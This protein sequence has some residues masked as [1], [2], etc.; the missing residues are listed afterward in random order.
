VDSAY[1]EGSRAINRL[2]TDFVVK[3]DGG[4]HPVRGGRW[5]LEPARGERTLHRVLA[6]VSATP[7]AV[8]TAASVYGSL[9]IRAEMVSKLSLPAWDEIGVALANVDQM[10]WAAVLDWVRDGCRGPMPTQLQRAM[11][12][13]RSLAS[14]PEPFRMQLQSL[15]Q[16]EEPSRWLEGVQLDAPSIRSVYDALSDTVNALE[17]IATQSSDELDIP[18][19][20]PCDDPALTWAIEYYAWIVSVIAGTEE[21]PSSATPEGALSAAVGWLAPFLAHAAPTGEE[22]LIGEIASAVGTETVADWLAAI[23]EMKKWVSAI[24]LGKRADVGK[25]N[26]ADVQSMRE[27]ADSLLGYVP[28]GLPTETAGEMHLWLVPL[29]RARLRRRLTDVGAWPVSETRPLGVYARSLLAA[30]RELTGERPA[31]GCHIPGCDATFPAHGNR[32]YCDYHRR[33]HD[34]DRHRNATKGRQ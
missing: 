29:L 22:D 20:T 12:L 13:V 9:R 17:F 15:M 3:P 31:Q 23:A 19:S 7:S 10:E 34:R 5:R 4:V 30:W 2:V 33:Q 28:D 18:V 6:G 24:E 8:A 21:A 26:Q 16:Q 11:P 1:Q 14:L 32:L 27:I 25:L